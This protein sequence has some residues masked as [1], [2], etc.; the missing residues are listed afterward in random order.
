[1]KSGDHPF[2]KQ[3]SFVFYAKARVE[4]QAK[5]NAMLTDGTFIRK[6]MLDQTIFDRVIAG[7]YASEHTIPKHIKFYESCCAGMT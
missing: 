5:I 1:M 2:V 7:L 6:E 4:T 3:D